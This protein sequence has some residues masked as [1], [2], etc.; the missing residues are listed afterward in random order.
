VSLEQSARKPSPRLVTLER[1]SRS[2]DVRLEQSRRNCSPTL[3]TLERPSRS[4]D[5]SL[6]HLFR[7]RSPTR[8]TREISTHSR[9]L[10]SILL[11]SCCLVPLHVAVSFAESLLAA[12][13]GVPSRFAR[14]PTTPVPP[15]CVFSMFL[16]VPTARSCARPLCFFPPC[17]RGTWPGT[18]PPNTLRFPVLRFC[19]VR[20]PLYRHR[21]TWPGTRPTNQCPHPALSTRTWRVAPM[22]YAKYAVCVTPMFRPAVVHV[23]CDSSS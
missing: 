22:R 1:P 21:G 6:V 18:R 7:K 19:R 13:V 20:T 8:V 12:L 11:L 15:P 4:N 16:P 9:H 3:V 2:N 23:T 5:V 10:M 14:P 17:H